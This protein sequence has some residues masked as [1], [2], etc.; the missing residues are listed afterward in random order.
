M[1]LPP[2]Y[3]TVEQEDALRATSRGLQNRDRFFQFSQIPDGQTWDF[4]FCGEY[5]THMICCWTY[6]NKDGRPV[7]SENEPDDQSWFNDAGWD[8]DLRQE[9]KAGKKEPERTPDKLDK[10]KQKLLMCCYIKQKPN[11]ICIAEIK[12]QGIRRKLDKYLADTE[13]CNLME[14]GL[15]NFRLEITSKKAGNKKHPD[16]D[17]ERYFLD[18]RGKDKKMVEKVGSVWNEQKLSIWLPAVYTNADPFAGQPATPKPPGAL[19]PTGRDELG[20]DLDITS[21]ALDPG[22][23][24]DAPDDW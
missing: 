7:T 8:Y 6:F 10:P 13:N 4:I 20:A 3:R 24:V 16:Y 17:L 1:P 5:P 15:Y 22:S 18:P 14:N 9:I 23:D 21:T 12:Q 11:Q 2:N 19:P